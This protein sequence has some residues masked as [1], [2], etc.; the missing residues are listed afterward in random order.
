MS[1]RK[2]DSDG[3]AVHSLWSQDTELISVPSEE[4]NL[5]LEI[6]S[7]VLPLE[8]YDSDQSGRNV[9]STTACSTPHESKLASSAKRRF[10]SSSEDLS[11]RRKIAKGSL[12][13]VHRPA[14]L[15]TT[16]NGTEF[17]N[18][19]DNEIPSTGVNKF[20]HG[21]KKPEVIYAEANSSNLSAEQSSNQKSDSQTNTFLKAMSPPTRYLEKTKPHKQKDHDKEP[22]SK[23]SKIKHFTE[24][25]VCLISYTIDE[26]KREIISLNIKEVSKSLCD[27]KNASNKLS[28]SSGTLADISGSD[29]GN[30]YSGSEKFTLPPK[31]SV[32]S[33]SSLSS[34]SSS[35]SSLPSTASKLQQ[36]LNKFLVPQVSELKKNVD[37]RCKGNVCQC[38]CSKFVNCLLK[39]HLASRC[40]TPEMLSSSSENLKTDSQ[41]FTDGQQESNKNLRKNEKS[42][43]PVIPEEVSDESKFPCNSSRSSIYVPSCTNLPVFAK[44]PGNSWFYPG[45]IEDADEDTWHT[46]SHLEVKFCDGTVRNTRTTNLFPAYLL[47]SKTEVTYEK[48]GNS[49]TTIIT[50]VNRLPNNELLLVSESGESIPFQKMCFSSAHYKELLK[51]NS[52][53]LTPRKTP[54][55]SIS[56]ANVQQ[57]KRTRKVVRS[58]SSCN[59]ESKPKFSSSSKKTPSSRTKVTKRG[60]GTTEG[61]STDLVKSEKKKIR[62]SSQKKSNIEVKLKEISTPHL[63][64]ETEKK[65]V[66][67]KLC[68]EG[69]TPGCSYKD[70]QKL[71]ISEQ[72]LS[73][74]TES[75]GD[76]KIVIDE[77]SSPTLDEEL[78][79]DISRRSFR[80]KSSL[81]KATAYNPKNQESINKLGPLPEIDCFSS[82]NF[83]LTHSIKKEK[84]MISHE[85]SY[86]EEETDF[87]D[88][89][90]TK[91]PFDYLW[92]KE[93]ILKG[94][95]KVYK[96]LLDIFKED[97]SNTVV[98]ADNIFETPNYL[99]AVSL[100]IPIYR[101]DLIINCCIQKKPLREMMGHAMKLP[102]GRSL[103]SG[104]WVET[105]TRC[106]LK[107]YC[108]LLSLNVNISTLKFWKKLLL[109]AGAIVMN[110]DG[111]KIIS[112]QQNRISFIIGD[113]ALPEEILALANCYEIPMVSTLW[114]SQSIIQGKPRSYDVHP[115]YSIHHIPS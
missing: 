93:Q 60:R 86:S 77:I 89:Y 61:S 81:K 80:T 68:L 110:G 95:G 30:V 88:Y 104:R 74:D 97:Y 41:E 82:Y 50:S 115:Q 36:S 8:P 112:E 98:I 75:S 9:P 56:I 46:S 22:A 27:S 26:T 106:S 49:E 32:T 24:E 17:T 76:Q 78:I 71:D 62:G 69:E 57:G 35:S 87:E 3:E 39:Q 63:G 107:G 31:L 40:I 84:P 113:A 90:E 66:V 25:F 23:E 14:P 45:I 29:G 7:S 19:S 79:L 91:I 44:W 108:C 42:S 58:G 21:L 34:V 13:P 5:S 109:N 20:L 101:H 100:G 65:E 59:S 99:L 64:V 105:S 55:F 94:G 51:E 111:I 83:V 114:V 33:T 52:A 1:F 102:N 12:S 11:P 96:S 43:V 4:N 70:S 53:V 2:S 37:Y 18:G 10:E 72:S 48:E 28:L 92:L 16:S 103:E 67:R 6:S 47:P 73:T 38:F 54:K 85:E 15:F